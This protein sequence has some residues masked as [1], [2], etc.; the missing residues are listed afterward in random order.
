MKTY[1][2]KLAKGAL[3]LLSM[4]CAATAWA[5]PTEAYW[6]EDA[7]R[8]LSGD[9][10]QPAEYRSLTLDTV[11]VAAYL[12]DAR[13]RGIATAISLPEPN[14]GFT[15]FMVIDS[16]TMPPELEAKYPDILS[17]KGSDAQGR[18][19]RLDVSLMGF[20]AMVF[21]RAGI[22][23]VR[24]ELLGSDNRYLSFK[25]AGLEVPGGTGQCEVH[26][27]H[28][29]PSGL[30]LMS[31]SAPMTVTG[32]TH[33][34]YRTAVAANN[35]YIAAVGGGTVAGGL[36]A[37]VTAVNRVNQVYEYE[38]AIQLQ[39]VPNNDLIMYPT[40]ATDPFSANGT[41]VINNST[42]VINAA[43]GVGN[44]DIGHVFTT[45][46]GGVAGLGVVCGG[47]KAR[48]TTG[49]P[50]PTGD[51]FYIDFVAH[52]MGHQFGG[53][54]P[55]NGS[56]GNCSGGNRNG[57][58]AYEPGSGTT[59]MAYAGICGADDLQAHSDP[60]FHAIS[61]QEITNFTQNSSTGGSCSIN[62]A[63]P[64]L[65]PVINT[66]GLTN[67]YTIPARTPFLLS[68]S[69]TDA[70]S[71]DAVTYSWE[72][73]DL[74]PQAPLSAGD[75]GTSPIFR[76]YSPV[77]TGTRVFP[78]LSTILGGPAIKGETLP[79]TNRALKFRLTARDERAG[80]GTSQ[81]ADI[82][83]TVA[84]TAGPFKVTGPIAAVSWGA[85][86]N[87][88]VTWDVAN[89][90]ISP[91]NCPNVDID[92]STDAGQ[93]WPVSLAS[94]VPNS[95]SA[96]I[97]VPSV[98]TS[99]ARVRVNCSNNIFFNIS[100][101][102]FTVTAASGTYTVGGSVSGLVG[103]GLALQ[104]NGGANLAINTNGAFSF[105]SALADGASYSVTI[106]GSPI[107][108]MQTCDVS[109]GSGTISGANV[110]NV[111][112]TCTTVTPTSF[113]VGGTVTGL[114]GTG[115]SLSLNS[116]PTLA[117][118]NNGAFSFPTALANGVT[119]TVTIGS[120]PV[121]P[122]Q[123]CA[124]S[125]GSG[126]IASADVSNVQ[127]TCTTVPPTPYTVSGT[128]TGLL[129]TGLK[130][131][132]NNGSNQVISG[133]GPF[134]FTTQ[135][136][137]GD[138]YLV[139]ITGQPTGPTQT[140]VVNN[141]S[142]TIAGANVTNVVVDCNAI[143]PTYTIG[144]SVSGLTGS[145][146]VLN[147]NGSTSLPIASNGA[148]T[149][150]GGLASGTGYAVTVTT[151]PGTPAQTC[152]ATNDSGTIGTSNVTDIAVT[153]VDDIVDRIFADGFEGVSLACQ[154]IQ[155]PGFEATDPNSFENPFWG[156]T[157]TNYGNALCFSEGCGSLPTH[158]GQ[159]FAYFG[160][161]QSDVPA[162]IATV[163]QSVVIPAG[164]NY[165]LNFWMYAPFVTTP[166]NDVVE[167]KVDG[168]SVLTL[169]EPATAETGGYSQRSVDLSN[170]ANGGSHQITIEYT[171]P[172]DGV[173]SDVFIDD[174]TLDCAP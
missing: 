169:N 106:G 63:N 83:L 157:S 121:S 60:Y 172:A 44:Y 147:L 77:S 32:V 134:G 149:F 57:S 61:L 154:L 22:W 161:F 88:T 108:P 78:S 146:L 165:M 20:Q 97:L 24:P 71:S 118:N 51:S 91:V 3:A 113:T 137:N 115:L 68:G 116:G 133:N 120:S 5:G 4:A 128:V 70:D 163:S 33:R 69:A 59:I 130:V 52:E 100:P 135:L 132:L 162:E 17:F 101:G 49:L 140:C 81:S 48:G 153:C 27:S 28:V 125:N 93:T 103:T 14:G 159:V 143:V 18:Q 62:T 141:G 119:Y 152:T 79:T 19:V 54:H 35:N 30:S 158:T 96:S 151:Q 37:T 105:P 10:P 76:A 107:S 150:T 127:V 89:T 131:R 73:W 46:S 67:G 164:R 72:E 2:V 8:N 170:Y 23:V 75:N 155:D 173:M 142:G 148:F 56:I 109:N 74:G 64:N 174:V 13:Q 45:G 50:N 160:G 6:Q 21:D 114:A 94:S 124:I 65:A 123:I 87:Q 12:K 112:V 34:K 40:A 122:E 99:Q 129:G 95:G 102:N 138:S 31:A 110:T 43:I 26:N 92:L 16:G 38:M 145:G 29:D 1:L 39:L 111:Q 9:A 15:D 55:F 166:L 47:S 53:N 7:S 126:T 25:R 42:S 98:S 90:N 11:G 41:G 156:S 82:A 167:V 36:A 84:N 144:G 85:G 86:Q 104:L 117:I 136:F 58:T 168:T 80:N 139:S 66:A 171:H